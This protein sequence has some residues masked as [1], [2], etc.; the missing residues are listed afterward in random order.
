MFEKF[1]NQLKKYKAIR[2]L[3]KGYLPILLFITFQIEHII[4]EGKASSTD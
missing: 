3:S 2:V 1:L 4:T